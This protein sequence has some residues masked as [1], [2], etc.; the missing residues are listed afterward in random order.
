MWDVDVMIV[1]AGPAAAEAG[2]SHLKGN[3]LSLTQYHQTID[4][5]SSHI[6]RSWQRFMPRKDAGRTPHFGKGEQLEPQKSTKSTNDFL[7]LL[8]LFVAQI[9]VRFRGAT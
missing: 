8:R 4:A 6:D 2:D 9:L 7:S 1:V 3:Q 5:Y